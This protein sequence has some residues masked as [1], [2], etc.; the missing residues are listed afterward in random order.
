MIFFGG[1]GWGVGGT[2]IVLGEKDGYFLLGMGP[3]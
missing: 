2:D 3:K 1:G